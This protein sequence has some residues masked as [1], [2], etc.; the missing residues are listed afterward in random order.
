MKVG[1]LQAAQFAVPR[2]RLK[3]R[4]YQLAKVWITRI[5]QTLSL[6]NGE[7]TDAGGID[8]NERL[9]PPPLRICR[10]LAL[11]PRHVQRGPQ[12]GPYAVGR[13][14]ASSPRVITRHWLGEVLILALSGSQPQRHLGNLAV[15]VANAFG[16]ERADFDLAQRAPN[17][18]LVAVAS[19]VG[20][21][22]IALQIE[23][24]NTPSERS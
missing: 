5:H 18:R 14:L 10:S 8:A 16:R 13:H 3:C 20:G 2:A 22:A 12:S 21:F 6:R 17:M 7:I 11:A 15:P 4:L 24:R 19:I 23:R 1:D 9:N